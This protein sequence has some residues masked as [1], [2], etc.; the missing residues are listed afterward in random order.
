MRINEEAL[1]NIKIIEKNIVV[2]FNSGVL[3]LQLF[4][5]TWNHF[6]NTY[7]RPMSTEI[8]M[9]DTELFFFLDVGN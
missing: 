2:A 4:L 8:N 5:K 7:V 1:T 3:R 9:P 6:W